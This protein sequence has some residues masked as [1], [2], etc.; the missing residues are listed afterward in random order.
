MIL[1][2]EDVRERSVAKS[3]RHVDLLSVSTIFEN[4]LVDHF[5]K[6]GLLSVFQY[7]FSCTRLTADHLTAVSCWNARALWHLML[8]DL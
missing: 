3:N 5:E 1:V 8:L 4:R 6:L 2:L 7:C